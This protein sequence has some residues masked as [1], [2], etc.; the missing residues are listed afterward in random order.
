MS[1]F[2]RGSD[3]GPCPCGSGDGYAA[4]CGRLHRGEAVAETAEQL[5]RSRYAAFVVRDAGHLVRTW[6]P[7]TRPDALELG[8]DDPD[9]LGLTILRTS[10]GGAS[11]DSGEVEFRAAYR[12]GALH[13]RSRFVR[14]GGR[15]V[16]LDGT[17]LD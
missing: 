14:R 2:G 8:D 7:R 5:M 13:E 15:W 11:D 3:T 17:V 12:G 16:Y 9:W 10:G 6:H 4:C 1:V